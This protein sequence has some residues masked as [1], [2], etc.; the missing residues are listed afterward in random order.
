M[1]FSVGQE[2]TAMLARSWR[3]GY[4]IATDVSRQWRL[5]R[6]ETARAERCIILSE[7]P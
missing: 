7:R 6:G 5:R 4:A 1:K 3:T 2:V